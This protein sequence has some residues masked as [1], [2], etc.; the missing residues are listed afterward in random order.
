LSTLEPDDLRGRLET[1]AALVPLLEAPDGDFGHWEPPWHGPDGT[2]RLPQFVTGPL[3][4]T[5]MDAV[6]RGR[7]MIVGFDWPTWARTD[8]AQALW[9][10][11]AALATATPDQLARFLTALIRSERFSEGTL[12]EAHASGLLLRIA[13]RAERLAAELGEGDRRASVR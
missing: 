9:K 13:R 8:E 12:D 1:L 7:W 2:M 4:D 6:A 10:D 3:Y 11:P 5:L